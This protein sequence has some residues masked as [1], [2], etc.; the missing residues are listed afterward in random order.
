MKM[1]LQNKIALVTGSS[2]GIGKATA[3]RLAADGAFVIIHG[4]NE[5]LTGTVQQE[6]TEH[7]GKATSINA[8]IS[9]QAGIEFLFKQLDAIL[10]KQNKTTFDILVNNAGLG[11]ICPLE[12]TTEEQ[13]DQLINMNVKAPFFITKKAIS[14]LSDGGRIINVSSIVTRMAMP[15]VA[16]YSMTKGSINTMTLWLAK[17]LGPRQITVNSVSPGVIDT[18]MNAETL[19]NPEAKKYIEGLSTL[20]RVGKPEDVADTIAFLASDDARW[21]SGQNIEASGGSF[22]G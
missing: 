11:L 12:E 20:G 16:A 5:K 8:D 15:T 2:R 3:L 22:L 14:R 1:N 19:K 18:D 4:T 13:F 6:I 7:G 21:I 17:Q 9:N 10:K